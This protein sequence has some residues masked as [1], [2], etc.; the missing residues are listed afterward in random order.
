MVGK[1]D[2]PHAGMRDIGR[3]REVKPAVLDNSL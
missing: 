3:R 2:N 1:G